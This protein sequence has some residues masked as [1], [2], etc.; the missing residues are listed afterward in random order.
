MHRYCI[1]DR[2]SLHSWTSADT[3]AGIVYMCKL[4]STDGNCTILMLCN[5][6]FIQVLSEQVVYIIHMILMLC[7]E[8][9]R[10]ACCRN[11]Y[12]LLLVHVSHSDLA[13]SLTCCYCFL[14]SSKTQTFILNRVRACVCS[15][16]LA[17][18]DTQMHSNLAVVLATQAAA[19]RLQK[20]CSC[21]KGC[22][23][24]GPAAHSQP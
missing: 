10:L 20:C 12:V 3:G 6:A 22:E 11:V 8:S 24:W 15:S 7:L 4:A 18:I 21:K 5:L 23:S 16:F 14:S 13:I 1:F 2:K 19:H 17:Y 9:C